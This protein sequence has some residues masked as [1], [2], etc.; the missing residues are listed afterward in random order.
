MSQ[1]QWVMCM[2]CGDVLYGGPGLNPIPRECGCTATRVVPLENRG[3]PQWDVAQYEANAENL[4]AE[5]RDAVFKQAFK[6]AAEAFIKEHG[7]WDADL[8][9]AAE[10]IEKA[11]ARVAWAAQ[12]EYERVKTEAPR[13]P[14]IEYTEEQLDPMATRVAVPET[15]LDD[16]YKSH[17]ND[18]IQGKL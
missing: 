10:V 5:A 11:K 13:E 15:T 16:V 14:E 17:M 8:P 18:L 12:Q 2:V 3:V 4:A 7:L 9:E 6:E 1:P